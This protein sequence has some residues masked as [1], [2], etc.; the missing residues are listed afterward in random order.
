VVRSASLWLALGLFSGGLS[1]CGLV[2]D[3]RRHRVQDEGGV[4]APPDAAAAPAPDAADAP[5]SGACL[6][7]DA[8]VIHQS[9]YFV[10]RSD[11]ET[12]RGIRRI[13]GDLRIWNLYDGSPSLDA[14]RCLTRVDG[15]FEIASTSLPNLDGLEDLERVGHLSL[16]FDIGL[17]HLTELAHLTQIDGILSVSSNPALVDLAGLEGLTAIGDYFTAYNNPALLS[18]SGLDHLTAIA[19]YV[20]LQVNPALKDV[21]SLSGVH[22]LGSLLVRGNAALPALDGFGHLNKVRDQVLISGAD[23]LKDLHGLGGLTE[24]GSLTVVDN[25]GLISLAGVEHVVSVTTNV[26]IA[27][28]ARLNDVSA[29]GGV[30]AFAGTLD[31]N[32]N[33]VLSRCTASALATKLGVTCRS[34]L[35]VECSAVCTCT[36]NLNA[37]ACGDAGL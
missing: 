9:L 15:M 19:N 16:N 18:L 30:S 14:L 35:P 5:D 24:V 33:P 34:E 31:I 23:A 37:T 2:D 28:N 1:A 29:L 22:E 17:R 4:A 3:T 7:G 27:R 26:S 12:L 32:S 21:S 10:T 6:D 36:G 20:E 13:E 25:A 11:I 8:G